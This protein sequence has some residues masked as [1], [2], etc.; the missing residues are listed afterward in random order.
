M[1]IGLPSV[2]FFRYIDNF[3]SSFLAF[4]A[5]GKPR[6]EKGDERVTTL[7]YPFLSL[8]D[9]AMDFLTQS[10]EAGLVFA[11]RILRFIEGVVI[12]AFLDRQVCER[13]LL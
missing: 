5:M 12:R 11:H 8:D 3:V 10:A 6:K 4:C 9:D 7:S 13:N 1:K 2:F